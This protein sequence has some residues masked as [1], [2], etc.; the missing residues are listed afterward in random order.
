VPIPEVRHK[1]P[2]LIKSLQFNSFI[3]SD[4]I[5]KQ[6]STSLDYNEEYGGYP[7]DIYSVDGGSFELF[8]T[9]NW[10]WSWAEVVSF[11]SF[12]NYHSPHY[13]QVIIIIIILMVASSLSSLFSSSLSSSSSSLPLLL[14]SSSSSFTTYIS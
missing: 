6:I 2:T 7:I 12:I 1:Y 10:Y 13:F 5:L 14:L 9:L 4:F 11:G 3:K 8:V